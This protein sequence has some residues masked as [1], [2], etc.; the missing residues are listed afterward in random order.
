MQQI[1]LTND[2]VVSGQPSA[3][4][5]VML[6]QEG[7]KTI[8]NLRTGKETSILLNP[9]QERNI[10]EQAQMLYLHIP[11]E[12]E[13]LR[14]DIITDFRQQL[15]HVPTPLLIHC[16]DGS[17]SAALALMHLGASGQISGEEARRMVES[18][19]IPWDPPGLKQQ[20]L[21]YIEE[22]TME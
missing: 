11:I 1:R 3:E 18:A 20:T 14:Y 9:E 12:K 8:I 10:V 21:H 4:R 13:A 17:L 2:I 6:A 7:F 15:D 19:G 16:M 22:N 5:L